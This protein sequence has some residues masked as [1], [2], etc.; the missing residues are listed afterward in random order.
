MVPNIDLQQRD[1]NMLVGPSAAQR[2]NLC[3]TCNSQ[4]LHSVVVATRR[5]RLTATDQAVVLGS[6]VAGLL[7]DA[8]VLTEI[9]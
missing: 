9:T 8:K 3:G 1:E 4:K 5:E 2:Q 6:F 7:R